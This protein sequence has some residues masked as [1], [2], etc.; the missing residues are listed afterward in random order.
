MLRIFLVWVVVL[1]QM[2]AQTASFP[3]ESLSV[4]GTGISK[5]I[6]LDLAGL[7]V[8]APVDQ[9]ALDDASRKLAET[10]M[11]ESV[12]YNYAQ[13]PKKG[14]AL[15]LRLADPKSLSD[16]SID[17]PGVNEDE[18]WQ[19]LASRYPVLNRKVPG[20][21]AAQRFV[22]RKLE[23]HLAA[24][25][26]GHKVGVQVESDLSRGGRS[27]ILFQPD[28]LPRIATI[29][30]TG[31]NE[32]TAAQLESLIPKDM[33]EHGYTDRLFRR[34]VELNLRRAYE[35]R[36]M[37]RMRFPSI[38]AH[39][40]TGW[41]VSVTTSVEEGA[42]FTLGDVQVLGDKLPID[43]MLKAANFRKG[44]IANWTEIQ[45]SI[46]DLE[47]PVK[48]IG[49][50]HASAKPERILN[51][52]RHVL[53]IK[54]PV[55]LGPLCKFGQVRITGLAPDLEA[56]ARKIWSLNP[57][58]PFDY[59]YPREFFQAFFRTVDSHQFKKF[60]YDMKQGVGENVMDFALVFEPR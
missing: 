10:G 39:R 7:H 58:D 22:E 27:I 18:V 51:D 26:E 20:N 41:S 24:E 5:D 11:F 30:F 52:E 15:T 3:L 42:K 37:Y 46:W 43:A 29:A 14:Y 23:E 2:Q 9:S 53:D 17:I 1:G 12:N 32:L 8:G 47:K 21:E 19:W 16:A 55:N 25:L 38:T 4:E 56:K 60:N 6:V 45:N 49:Y 31:Q 34:A 50:L 13:G 33:R 54:L 57:G 36:G 40:E 35:E 28:P 48:R 44:E 59:E